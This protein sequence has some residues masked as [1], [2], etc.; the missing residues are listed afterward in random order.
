MSGRKAA[1]EGC[2]AIR[3]LVTLPASTADAVERAQASGV[4]NRRFGGPPRSASETMKRLIILGL[5]RYEAITEKDPA[6]LAALAK[7]AEG[8]G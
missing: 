2:L 6:R 3:K 1:R 8:N 5:E 4:D 7:E